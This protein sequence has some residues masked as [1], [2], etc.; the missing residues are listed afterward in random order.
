MPHKAEA[1]C[2]MQGA[3]G[4]ANSPPGIT[5]LVDAEAASTLLAAVIAAGAAGAQ[6][7]PA[8]GGAHHEGEAVGICGAQ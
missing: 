8:T 4:Q 5:G 3:D 2:T 6:P 7:G 1:E